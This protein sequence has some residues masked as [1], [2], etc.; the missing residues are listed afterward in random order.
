MPDAN[1]LRGRHA[2]CAMS[3]HEMKVAEIQRDSS[4]KI[5]QLFAESI[6]RLVPAE[7]KGVFDELH[8]RRLLDFFAGIF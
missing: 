1:R 6:V 4:F 5:F 2:N 3:F 7:R 8:D